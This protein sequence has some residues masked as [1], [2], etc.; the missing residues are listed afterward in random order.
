MASCARPPAVEASAMPSVLAVAQASTS[1][2]VEARPKTNGARFMPAPNPAEATAKTNARSARLSPSSDSSGAL[3][4]VAA[5]TAR[6]ALGRTSVVLT[7]RLQ[8]SSER[9]VC[10]LRALEGGELGGRAARGLDGQRQVALAG[11]EAARAGL[12]DER[13]RVAGAGHV[14]AGIAD[15]RVPEERGIDARDVSGDP[16]RPAEVQ[17]VDEHRGV[18]A[19]RPGDHM[20]GVG[21]SPDSRVDRELQA[22]VQT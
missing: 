10:A 20:G 12:A 18:R 4:A 2:G 8:E 6:H 9:L 7:I 5:A 14:R 13:G 3:S 22:D 19:L 16:S 21:E 17:R 11:K 15:L 1:I